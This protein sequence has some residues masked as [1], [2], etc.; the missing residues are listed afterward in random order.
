[1]TYLRSDVR[2]FFWLPK[3][4]GG[5]LAAGIQTMAASVALLD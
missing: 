3:T 4:A 1:M 2:I 5:T